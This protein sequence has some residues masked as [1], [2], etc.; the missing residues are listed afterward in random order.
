MDLRIID[1]VRRF[2]VGEIRLPLMQRDYVWRPLK[3]VKLL[4]SLY[5]RWPIG[6]FYVWHTKHDRAAKNRH[7]GKQV[8]LRSL[9]TFYGFLLDGQQ[10]LT[11]LSMAIEGADDQNIST[12]AFFDI[13]NERFFL[14]GMKKTIQQRIESDDPDLVPLCDLVPARDR[15]E[16]HLYERIDKV[17]ERLTERHKVGRNRIGESE[18]RRRLNRVATMLDVKALCEEFTDEHEENA[19]ELFARLNK[20]GTS[21]SVGDVEAAR[22]SQEGTAHIVG[23][24][25]DFVQQPELRSLG[26]NFVFVTRALVT[27]H[28]GSSTFSSLPKNWAADAGD[29]KESWRRT[30]RGLQLACKLVREELGW[31]TRRWLPSINALI[32]VAYLLGDQKGKLPDTETSQ[33]KRFLL[34]TGLRGLFHGSV[35]T[36]IN[37]FVNPLRDESSPSKRRAS[38]L[39][40][41]IPQ[42]RLYKVKAEDIKSTG[43]MYSPLMQTYLAY[44]VDRDAQSWP[45][46]RA[47][48]EIARRDVIGDQLAVHHIFPKKF[49]HQFDIPLEKL[50]TVANYAIL[51]QAD[52]AELSDRD[53]STAH[54]ELSPAQREAASEQLFF[55]GS[56]R[57]D[58]R[59]Y[60]ETVDF[61]AR[62]M[63]DA[64]N[65][66]LGLGKR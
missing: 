57:L 41:K 9:D 35:E 11:S 64:L 13:E 65:D 29:V 62:E 66:F 50:N 10:R 6:C 52:N 27:I 39:V 48:T 55:R 1:L 38:M 34:L 18:V 56:E 49:M 28:R 16:A 46:G 31:T 45:S 22:L 23:P 12:R 51:S 43:R 40:K 36:A 30:E 37:G 2:D 44:L 54:R 63:A 60:D 53:P 15:D 24:M 5:T 21:L 47:I 26:L 4:D 25:R 8:V 33:L 7:K 58:H 42:N 20:G 61:R 17:I 19:I 14:G 3:V 32:P 59:S